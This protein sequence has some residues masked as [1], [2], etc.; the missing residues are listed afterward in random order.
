VTEW[1]RRET[2]AIIDIFIGIEKISCTTDHPFWV[3]G[4]GWVLAHQLKSGTVLQTHSG[5]SLLI[6]EIR[7]RDEVT[8]VYNVE[9][10]GLHTYF[11]SN[12]E[13]LSHNMCGG[14][15]NRAPF[16]NY[17]DDLR[18]QMERPYANDAELNNLL[19][20][21]YRPNA[22]VGS[23][24]TAAAVRQEAITGEP[25]G[26]RFHKQKAEDSMRALNRWLGNNPNA[27][28]ADRAAA[29]N[30]LKDL[31]NALGE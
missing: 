24:S 30:V 22:T 21:I 6:D 3:Q 29:E 25:I 2:S 23:G 26:G 11:V 16:E 27:P 7:R 10:D 15:S 13:I 20:N 17:L 9:I 19:D 12:L 14:A 18:A 28:T 4:R 8:Q 5:E 1:Y 31:G